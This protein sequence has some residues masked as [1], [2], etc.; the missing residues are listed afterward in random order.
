MP[1]RETTPRGQTCRKCGQVHERCAGHSKRTGGP[2]G[3]WPS[4]GQEVC[5]N[6]GGSSPQAIAGAKARELEEATQAAARVAWALQGEGPVE[7]PLGELARLAGEV[8]AWKDFVRDQVATLDGILTYWVDR[9][10]FGPD[11]EIARS[12]AVE[13]ARSIVT[14]YERSQDR[15]A[16]ILA[17]IVKLDI[18]E[19]MTAL[20]TSQANGI[21]EAVRNGLAEVEIE[22]TIRQAA[23]EAIADRL[24][25]ISEPAPPLP[26]ELTA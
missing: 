8:V 21:V 17:T 7:D 22:A 11:G 16:K 24:A 18:A 1:A 25:L 14:V 4:K 23:L 2:C 15:A 12:E 10:F 20:R 3:Q 5:K 26:K 6:H 13:N 19:R 9:D